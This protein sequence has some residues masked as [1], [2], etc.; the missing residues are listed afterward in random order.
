MEILQDTIIELPLESANI[1]REPGFGLVTHDQGPGDRVVKFLPA[2]NSPTAPIHLTCLPG[3]VRGGRLDAIGIVA[4]SES[5][6]LVSY[7]Q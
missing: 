4:D 3:A 1:D 2:P 5:G 7:V 6:L